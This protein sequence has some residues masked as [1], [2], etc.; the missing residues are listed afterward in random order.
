MLFA[1]EDCIVLSTACVDTT[2]L[3]D[4]A[5]KLFTPVLVLDADSREFLYEIFAGFL[6]FRRRVLGEVSSC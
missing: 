4:V 5:Q 6:F 1:N 2:R 3:L